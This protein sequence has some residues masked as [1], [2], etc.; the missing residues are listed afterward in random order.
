MSLTAKQKHDLKKFVKELDSHRAMHTEL[1]TVYIPAG[2][3]ITKIIQHLG[4][5]QGTASNIKS[6]STRK[7]VISALERMIQHLK[8]FRQTPEHGLAVFSGN[9]ARPGQIDLRVWSIE[10]PIPL[11]TRIYR[12]D[13][14][15]Q[16]DLLRDMLESR[17]M[18][19]LVVMDRREGVVAVLKGKSIIP[20]AKYTSNVPGKTRAGGQ[21]LLPGTL[22]VGAEGNIFP[23]SKAP[24]SVKSVRDGRVEDSPV[25]DMW[26]TEKSIV[27]RIVTKYPRIEIES[28]KEHVFF[29]ATSEGIKEKP[30]EE[31]SAGDFL[32]MPERISVEGSRQALHPSRFYNSF[33]ISQE[34]S[35][36]VKKERIAR[37]LRQKDLAKAMGVSQTAVSKYELGLRNIGRDQLAGLCNALGFSLEEFISNYTRPFSRI[38]YVLPEFLDESFAHFLGYLSGEGSIEKDRITFFEQS[39]QVAG[40]LQAKFDSLLNMRA[41]YRF[42]KDKNYHQLR[43]SSR[44]LVRLISSL[45]PEANQGLKSSIPAKILESPGSVLAAFFKG[46]FDAEGYAANSGVSLGMN[47]RLMVQQIQM[48]LLRFGII[49]SFIEYDNRRNPYSSNHRYSVVISERQSLQEFQRLIGFTSL[50]KSLAVED[51]IQLKTIKSSVR[52]IITAGSEV[53]KIIEAAGFRKQAF[54]RV[55]GFFRNNSNI[56]LP[57]KIASITVRSEKVRMVDI[58]VKNQN[59]IACGLLVHNSS[60]RFERLREGAAKEFF[61]RL[62]EH[63]K[64]EFFGKPGLKG[65]LVGG[66]GTTKHEFVEGQFLPTDLKNRVI[67]IRDLSYTDEFGLQELVDKSQDVLAAEEVVHEKKLMTRFFELLSTRQGMVSYGEAE[68]M[69][70]LESG[71]VDILLLS[72]DLSDEK[73]A[74]FEDVAGKFGSKVEII[75]TETREGAQ[76]RDFGMV[77]AILRYEVGQ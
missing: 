75:S 70:L 34:G 51:T 46:L 48:S 19:G 45:F 7:N 47:N 29:V 2:Y 9:I 11:Q 54:T 25:T 21:C 44:P 22:I 4:Q 63:V 59:F 68:V 66:P 55:S 67:A 6:A 35:A 57:V 74:G 53:R 65:L 39:G 64:D 24:G 16:L 42:R 30:A 23:I 27:Y 61:T 12:C 33:I 50:R 43:Y 49:A 40:D 36:C 13:K 58:S 20:L 69:R 5:E 72:E 10:P 41:S 37:R 52:Q 32:V 18:Y 71:V 26:D 62:G 17:E 15:F 60:Q 38:S 76:L 73:I 56:L 28:S 31:L 77:A 8:L 3:E 1:I 14:T